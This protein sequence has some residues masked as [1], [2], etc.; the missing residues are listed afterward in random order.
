MAKKCIYIAIFCVLAAFFA[1]AFTLSACVASD[2][3]NW[4]RSTISE[5]YFVFDGDYSKVENLDRLSI[6][7]MVS[8]LDQYCAFYTPEQYREVLSSNGGN[9]HGVGV[10][11]SYKSGA[12][13]EV[14]SVIGN[15][16][17]K[18][19]GITAGDILVCAEVGEETIN[20]GSRADFTDFIDARANGES[21]VLI[22]S[23][24]RKFPIVKNDYTASYAA[25]YTRDKTFETEYKTDDGKKTGKINESAGGFDFL[26]E[27]AGYITLSQF[28]GGAA[29]EMGALIAKFNSENCTTLILDLRKNGG[30][31][32]DLMSQI[33]GRFTSSLAG[34]SIS[35][36]AKYKDGS[37]QTS[38]CKKYAQ[39]ILPAG[40][41][42]YVMAD[43][44]TA[45]ASEALIGVLV[46]YDIIDYDDIYLSDY[47]DG[48]VR[49]YGKGIMQGTYTY[50]TGE[51]LKITIAGLYWANGR[52]IH[53]TGVTPADGC[54]ILAAEG[55]AAPGDEEVRQLAGLIS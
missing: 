43:S 22:T 30:G 46:S 5:Q 17:A 48:K 20:F 23:D 28:Y 27:G 15:S 36:I 19:A 45:S 34:D 39:N 37:Q 44:A 47:G 11:Y 13:I 18:K 32:V 26:P 35:M 6:D 51:A 41:K 24:G 12:G 1:A 49:S 53:G 9:K 40:T 31:Y 50:V 29:D 8:R 55:G 4:V 2:T 52:T 14:I 25:L 3:E 54:K 10:N 42:V 21:F 33:A 16:P 38:Y 7:E